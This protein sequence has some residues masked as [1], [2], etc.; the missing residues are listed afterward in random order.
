MKVVDAPSFRFLEFCPEQ[1]RIAPL[2]IGVGTL[3]EE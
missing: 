2:P 1:S 3:L